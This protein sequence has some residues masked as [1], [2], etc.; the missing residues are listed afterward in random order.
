[1][2]GPAAISPAD[3]AAAPAAD[4]VPLDQV[5]LAMDVVDTLRHRQDLLATELDEERRQREF[6]ARVQGIYEAQGIEVSPE[7]IAEAVRSLRENR[8]VYRPPERTFAVRLAEVYVERGKWGKRLALAGVAMLVL[9]LA[10]VVPAGIRRQGLVDAFQRQ[11]ASVQATHE[12]MGRRADLLQQELAATPTFDDAPTLRQLLQKAQDALGRG[13]TRLDQLRGAMTPPPDPAAYPDARASWDERVQAWRTT[14]TGV[15]VD[16]GTARG[17]L[18]GVTQL[19]SLGFQL[20]AVLERLQGLQPSTREQAELDRLRAAAMTAIDAG[21]TTA[22]QKAIAALREQIDRVLAARERQAGMRTEF[23]GLSTALSGVAVEP[24]A[25]A[26]LAQL[27]AAVEQALAAED[28]PRVEE[29]LGALRE[30]VQIL[31]Q[32]YELR[33]VSRPQDRSGVWRHPVGGRRDAR[34][35]YIIVE[36]I[37]ADG[38]PLALR[39]TSEEDQRTR[40]VRQFGIR[41]PESVYEAVK[42]DKLDNGIVDNTLFGTKRRGARVPEYRFAVEGGRITEW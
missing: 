3:P 26:E 21:D 17:L 23:A 42:N 18:D 19:R 28:W 10:I 40:S 9:W 34:N 35:Y 7:V 32:A 33:I 12:E 38:R 6:T 29:Q 16:L 27:R 30:L 20:Q 5:M 41:V 37:G 14:L 24:E 4:P 36:A 39:V 8:F 31:D 15:G 25:E 22:G 11:V 13:R 2:T 1:M